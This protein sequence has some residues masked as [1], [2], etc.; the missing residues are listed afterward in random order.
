MNKFTPPKLI[1]N[2]ASIVSKDA[3]LELVAKV[4]CYLNKPG[5]YTPMFLMP[6]AESAYKE[7]FSPGG[8]SFFSDILVGKAS[9]TILNGIARINCNL[10]FLIGLDD[11]QKSFLN[12][13]QYYNVIFIEIN[14]ISELEVQLKIL[15]RTF[16]GYF[17][18]RKNDIAKGLAYSIRCNKLLIVNETAHPFQ[19]YTIAQEME[20]SLLNQRMISLS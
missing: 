16:N 3:N 10:V 7:D 19:V 12:L 4:S 14:T 2:I 9:R 11:I 8:D 18:C 6:R 1:K 17:Y 15:D 20:L 5:A 13:E